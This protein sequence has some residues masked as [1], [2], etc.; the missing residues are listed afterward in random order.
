MKIFVE[1]KI[2]EL[3][4]SCHGA[5]EVV[6]FCEFY[7]K[8]SRCGFLLKGKIVMESNAKYGGQ[9]CEGRNIFVFDVDDGCLV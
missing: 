5:H 1:R 9:C 4:W 8:C 6:V 2:S 7:N 3:E